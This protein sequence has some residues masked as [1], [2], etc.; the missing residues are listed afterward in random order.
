MH[1]APAG[2]VF[3]ARLFLR[4][5]VEASIPTIS[6]SIATA[7]RFGVLLLRGREVRPAFKRNQL[8][9]EAFVLLWRLQMNQEILRDSNVWLPGG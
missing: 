7:R 4:V 1:V 9:L 6:Q 2:I 8:H 3:G 5:A